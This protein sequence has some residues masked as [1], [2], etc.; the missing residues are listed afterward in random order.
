MPESQSTL[1]T[2]EG[3]LEEQNQAAISAGDE[4][5]AEELAPITLDP[6]NLVEEIRRLQRE[7]PDFLKIF[8]NEVGNMADRQNRRNFEPKISQLER[9]LEAERRQ[10]RKLEILGMTEKDIEDKFSKDPVFAKEYAELVHYNPQDQDDTP[11]LITAAWEEAVQYAADNG[12]SQE[13][14][15]KVAEKA[16]SGGYEASHWSLS[17]Q[18]L[19]RDIANEIIRIKSTESKADPKVNPNIVNGSADLSP[20]GRGAV[21]SFSFKTVREFR[22][23]PIGKQNEILDSPGGMEYVET[24]MKKG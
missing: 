19:E 24:L 13:F 22:E 9:E 10:R 11:Q 1:E 23:L 21:T 5:G 17:I 18:K 2:A 20:K 12:V 14:I 7:N 15:N 6:K 3:K 4:G 8:N 16:A